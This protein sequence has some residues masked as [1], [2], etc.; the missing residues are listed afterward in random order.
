MAGGGIG[1]ELRS[2]T[3]ADCR[4]SDRR[5]AE[6]WVT[7]MPMADMPLDNGTK[8]MF[9]GSLCQRWREDSLPCTTKS[10]TV[11]V[12]FGGKPFEVCK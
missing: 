7:S 2:I 8:S 12:T 5:A 10:T 1:G 11:A 6:V 9:S 3:E 4:G